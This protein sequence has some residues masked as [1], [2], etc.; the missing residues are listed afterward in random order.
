MSTTLD[1]TSEEVLQSQL[2]DDS[3]R[4]LA[5][6]GPS[7]VRCSGKYC[8]KGYSSEVTEEESEEES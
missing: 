2:A 3:L 7:A 1:I 5:P 8:E 6:A 4:G